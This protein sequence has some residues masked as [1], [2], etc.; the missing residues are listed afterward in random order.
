[1]KTIVDI[2]NELSKLAPLCGGGH[3][4]NKEIEQNIKDISKELFNLA[5][6]LTLILRTTDKM[7]GIDNST[8]NLM[9]RQQNIEENK[10]RER[11]KAII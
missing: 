9:L 10:R 3:L 5:F 2:S 6:D 8:Y 4:T 11:Q 7:T 1:M